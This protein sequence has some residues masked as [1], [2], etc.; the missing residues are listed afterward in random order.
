MKLNYRLIIII[1]ISAVSFYS[2]HQDF[3]VINSTYSSQIKPD[4][5]NV[6]F[7]HTLKASQ[8]A[9][10]ISKFP[11]GGANKIVYKN[12]SIYQYDINENRL[13]KIYDFGNLPFDSWNTYTSY[14][15][16]DI[17][18]SIAPGLGYD[19]RINNSTKKD[20]F[21]D[22]KKKFS[23]IYQFNITTQENKCIIEQACH[24][25]FSPDG[26]NILYL[27]KDT[28]YTKV[29]VYNLTDS[30]KSQI[31]ETLLTNRFSDLHWLNSQKVFVAVNDDSFILNLPQ[32][33]SDSS[34][35]V[36]ASLKKNDI[37][38][39]ELKHVLRKL[40]FS[41]WGFELNQHWLK[42]RDE[43][44]NDIVQLNGNFEYRKAIIEELSG[45]LSE[46]DFEGI[47]QKMEKYSSKL[48]GY[49]KSEYDIFSKETIELLNTYINQK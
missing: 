31:F 48:S 21:I 11:D 37:S 25:D 19:W 16:K 4:S 2:C 24:P 34:Q 23:G 5:N 7:F 44:I 33:F 18:Y 1:F 36:K 8:P 46:S 27:T 42:N 45:Y 32:N 39:N 35:I 43:Y 30:S 14:F 15:N 22:L 28:V 29:W 49:K 26:K 12:T 38:L 10:G 41:D 6:I 17:L 13:I 40:S 47:I 20:D 3:L 9:K